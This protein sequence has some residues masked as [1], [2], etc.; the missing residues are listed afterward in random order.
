MADWLARKVRN[1]EARQLFA[2]RG[3]LP[4]PGQIRIIDVK[5]AEVVDET[6]REFRVRH[7]FGT[8]PG[9][10]PS[11]ALDVTIHERYNPQRI[12]S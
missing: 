12:V 6:T 11:M 7:R 8:R 1:S 5:D 4:Q 3:V 10:D 2:D 9:V